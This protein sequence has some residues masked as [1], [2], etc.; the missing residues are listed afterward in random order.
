MH[1]KINPGAFYYG[2]PVILLST[3]ND[4]G[5]TNITPISSSWSLGE[6]VVIGIGTGTQAYEN[7]KS[8]REAVLNIV[9][10]NLI[11]HVD[12]IAKSSGKNGD[13]KW[14]LANLTPQISEFVKPQRVKESPLQAET[15]VVNIQ[16]RDNFAIVELK[17][18]AVQALPEILTQDN[19]VDPEKWKPMIYNFRHY[20]G[21]TATK[22]K[23]FKAYS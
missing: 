14:A 17:I 1:K 16:E 21:L 4:N 19:L 22:G 20:Q 6:M 10:E 11:N 18:L 2:F 13:D 3:L 23:H 5:T 15:K 12:S 9:S 7:L 8:H